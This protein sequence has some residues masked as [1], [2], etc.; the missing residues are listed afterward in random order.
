MLRFFHLTNDMAFKVI[1]V[2]SVVGA[3]IMVEF[4]L[5]AFGLYHMWTS[6]NPQIYW[7]ICGL[8]SGFFLFIRPFGRAF[9]VELFLF[10]SLLVVVFFIYALFSFL[11][12]P[13]Q[14]WKAMLAG[15]AA[16]LLIPGEVVG[17]VSYVMLYWLRVWFFGHR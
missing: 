10:V 7:M 17:V 9:L 16:F 4:L 14:E 3:I 2:L 6:F 12:Y 8:A 11:R 5:A 13:Q 1:F 15:G